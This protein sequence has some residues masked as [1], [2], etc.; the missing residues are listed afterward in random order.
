M[1]LGHSKGLVKKKPHLNFALLISRLPSGLEM[2]SW[3]FFNSPFCVD[4]KNVI[5]Y[6]IW[7]NLDR[8]IGKML[9]GR[10]F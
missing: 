6:I 2:P 3:T 9:Q 5:F 4:F 10:H 7:C 8:D 1:I